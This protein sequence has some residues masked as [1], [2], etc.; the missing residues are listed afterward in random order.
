MRKLRTLGNDGVQ[1]LADCLNS[2]LMGSGMSKR[3]LS[4]SLDL[5]RLDAMLNAVQEKRERGGKADPILTD[6]LTSAFQRKIPLLVAKLNETLSKL[7]WTPALKLRD[8][9]MVI[10]SFEFHTDSG[11]A[12]WWFNT[13]IELLLSQRELGTLWKL[14]DCR[15]CGLWFSAAAAHQQFCSDKCRVR[16]ASHSEQAK[17]KRAR[18]MRERY[19]PT[20]KKQEQLAKQNVAAK[21]K[22]TV[23]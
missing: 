11:S 12:K 3:L 14:M 21:A 4:F 7:R 8:E 2:H 9:E 18:Y 16:H 19:R 22:R 6:E 15:E 10:Q 20:I 13:L 1:I 23:S 5:R 17:A